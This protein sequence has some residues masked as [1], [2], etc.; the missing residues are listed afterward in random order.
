VIENEETGRMTVV[1]PGRP[2][3]VEPIHEGAEPRPFADLS[4]WRIQWGPIATGL[5]V[6]LT[7]MTLL[8]LL[9]AAIGL[10]AFKAGAAA[11][12]GTNPA[13][14]ARNAGVWAAVSAGLAFL[15]GGYA[16]SRTAGLRDRRWGS[17]HG[18]L[19]FMLAVPVLFWLAAQGLGA[20]LGGLSAYAGAF[21]PGYLADPARAAAPGVS[22]SEV[23]SAAAAARNAAWTAFVIVLLGL[24]GGALGGYM[25]VHYTLTHPD[26]R[27]Y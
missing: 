17:W 12:Q 8:S 11:V 22:P 7:A 26:Q 24:G 19:V 21:A 3:V 10:T 20:V 16:A 6:A 4:D 5:L 23:L 18:A 13:S 25:G 27:R 15:L 9:G 2:V 1:R 14:A